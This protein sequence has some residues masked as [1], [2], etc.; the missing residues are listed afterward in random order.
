MPASDVKSALD[1]VEIALRKAERPTKA[2][3]IRTLSGLGLCSPASTGTEKTLLKAVEKHGISIPEKFAALMGVEAGKPTPAS[4]TEPAAEE[5]LEDNA[6]AS[7]P[8]TVPS[9]VRTVTRAPGVIPSFAMLG[10]VSAVAVR[11]QNG[12]AFMT[13][14]EQRQIG[15][16]D[17]SDLRLNF[18]LIEFNVS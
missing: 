14:G 5:T 8:P 6:P 11:G 10:G 13:D 16:Y 17:E 15:G 2:V 1:E 9:Q 18:N 12:T 7:R 4:R 3:V